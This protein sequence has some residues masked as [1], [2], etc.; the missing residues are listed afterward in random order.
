M[1][2]FEFSI[3]FFHVYHNFSQALSVQLASSLK[4]FTLSYTIFS[5]NSVFGDLMNTF[6]VTTTV[7]LSKP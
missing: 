3:I 4:K 2:Q 5:I 7:R 6:D 1:L